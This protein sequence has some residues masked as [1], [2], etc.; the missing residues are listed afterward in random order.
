LSASS[1]FGADICPN[2][3]GTLTYAKFGGGFVTCRAGRIGEQRK[4]AEPLPIRARV[5]EPRGSA[6]GAATL[7]IDRHDAEARITASRDDGL[8]ASSTFPSDATIA[9]F[10]LDPDHSASA[11]AD[12]VPLYGVRLPRGGQRITLSLEPAWPKPTSAIRHQGTTVLAALA[13]GYANRDWISFAPDSSDFVVIAGK[14]REVWTSER[15]IRC[16]SRSL[17]CAPWHHADGSVELDPAWSPDGKHVAFVRALDAGDSYSGG[18][19]GWQAWRETRR[20][21]IADAASGAIRRISA[22]GGDVSW[23]RWI[24]AERLLFISYDTLCELN[25]RTGAVRRLVKI[26]PAGV[27]FYGYVAGSKRFWWTPD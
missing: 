10:W 17:T 16:S 22:A 6:R 25:T 15:L 13:K 19:K 26:D 24:A 21:M 12:A 1:T 27:G 9:L 14:Y 4:H 3:P 7:I 2:I 18:L 11:M 5:V 8:Y 20:L 23:P